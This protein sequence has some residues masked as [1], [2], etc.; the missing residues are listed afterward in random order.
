MN[1]LLCANLLREVDGKLLE[2]IADLTAEDY[3]LPTL[4]GHWRVRDVLA[5]LL[6]TQLRKLSMARDGAFVEKVEIRSAEDVRELVD[7]MNAEG[8]R[9]YRRLSAAVL[10]SLLVAACE[11]SAAFHEGLDPFGK[12]VFAVSW[13]GEAGSL[14]WFDTARELTERW[15]H[16]QQIRDATGRPGIMTPRLYGP[17]L[18]CFARVLPYA[19][20]DLREG[21]V[22]LVVSGD[23]GGTWRSGEG[24]VRARAVVPQGIAWR[25]FTKGIVVE[26]ARAQSILEGDQVLALRLMRLTAIVG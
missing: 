8:V 7:R 4:A 18:E 22:E 2:L 19:F 15:H 24:D 23:C 25:V 20:R 21:C 26:D 6:D 12:A 14:N 16:Q 17:V 3:D 11:E 10:R 5:H 1:P 9:V 13:A